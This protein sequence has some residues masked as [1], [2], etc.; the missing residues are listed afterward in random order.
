VTTGTPPTHALF[1]E[2][3]CTATSALGVFMHMMVK[4][5]PDRVC[6]YVYI[7]VYMYIFVYMYM[8]L[9]ACVCL[10][11]LMCA[12]ALVSVYMCGF[13]RV[14]VFIEEK[15]DES[16]CLLVFA[17]VCT[18]VCEFVYERLHVRRFMCA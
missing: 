6:V 11:V 18:G 9:Y 5:L 15:F 14:C 13:L 16:A 4:A 7:Y 17:F 2:S 10:C 1:N 3:I 8:Y 12:C